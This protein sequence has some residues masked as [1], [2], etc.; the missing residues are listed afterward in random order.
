MHSSIVLVQCLRVNSL[1]R[2][3]RL[4]LPELTS[5]RLGNSA[6][7]FNGDSS[8]LIMRSDDDEMKWWID[9][10]K[11]V[12]LTTIQ[13]STSFCYP[14]SITLESVSSSNNLTNSYTL[15]HHCGSWQRTSIQI[16][17]NHS[18]KEHLFFLLL[19]PRHHSRSS[20]V[21]PV[22]CFFHT[23]F[24]TSLLAVPSTENKSLHQD[25]RF[26]NALHNSE[27]NWISLTSNK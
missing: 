6:F 26:S 9:L 27:M 8:E 17:E 4:D 15:S 12:F 22:H 20:T 21:S 23:Q 3:W 5:I 19:I 14:R 7:C 16:Q 13:D 1:K 25:H 2:E 24:I 10:P 11:L 18:C